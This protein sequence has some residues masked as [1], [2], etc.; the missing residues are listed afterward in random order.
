MWQSACSGIELRYWQFFYGAFL[1]S[2]FI[3]G[4]QLVHFSKQYKL[5]N[6][7]DN[8]QKCTTHSKWI[9]DPLKATIH[10][11]EAVS[12]RMRSLVLSCLVKRLRHIFIMTHYSGN[13]FQWKRKPQVFWCQS[14]FPTPAV[15]WGCKEEE[16]KQGKRQKRSSTYTTVGRFLPMY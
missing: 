10:V 3:F 15:R 6:P 8:L 11:N 12:I 9:L 14:C 16:T 2:L 7:V 1:T 13:V 5:Q 4:Q